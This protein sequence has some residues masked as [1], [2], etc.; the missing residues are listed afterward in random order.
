MVEPDRDNDG[1]GDETQDGC[2]QSALYQSGCPLVHL[3]AVAHARPGGILVDVTPTAE[4]KVYAWGLVHWE[5]EPKVGQS[6]RRRTVGLGPTKYRW[7]AGGVAT[8]IKLALPKGAIR[9]LNRAP[10]SETL[11]AKVFVHSM[12]LAGRRPR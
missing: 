12:D 7:V 10:P 4:A 1:Y 8:R 11:R 6:H 3:D 2:P 5:L 9:Q